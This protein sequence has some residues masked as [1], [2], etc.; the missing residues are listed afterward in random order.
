MGLE[1]KGEGKLLLATVDG[2]IELHIPE[3]AA[4]LII[5]GNGDARTITPAL[6]SDV[7]PANSEHIGLFLWI[8]AND[9]L[10]G[11][12]MEEFRLAVKTKREGLAA[13]AIDKIKAAMRGEINLT[14]GNSN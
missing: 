13:I 3:D 7:I 12:L 1:G 8:C 4:A 14:D 11:L 5:L 6:E 10:R 9:E 2:V